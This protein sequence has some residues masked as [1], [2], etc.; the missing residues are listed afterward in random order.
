MT[1]LH[2]CQPHDLLRIAADTRLP[3][4]P[5]WV[6]ASLARAPWLVVRRVR[7]SAQGIPVGVRGATRAERFGTRVDPAAVLARCP[8][9]ALCEAAGH[10]APGA[11]P[12]RHL[13]SQLVSR[14]AEA[15]CAWGPTGSVGFELASGIP[16]THADSD[17]DLIL[18]CPRPLPRDRARALLAELDASAQALARGIDALIETPAGAVSLREYAQ[19]NASVLLRTLD[20]VLLCRDP[21]RI[22]DA[23]H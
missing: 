22:R 2:D 15:G 19:G 20:G 16:V 1:S 3:G 9:E 7:A 6:A 14:L 17:L 18:R 5:A 13:C 21:W 8:P 10:C 12:A 11:S 4:A 23:A